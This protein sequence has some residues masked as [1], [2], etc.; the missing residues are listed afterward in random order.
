MITW[1]PWQVAVQLAA[2]IPTVVLILWAK[3]DSWMEDRKFYKG[4]K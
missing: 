3:F 1:E 2:I 4:E